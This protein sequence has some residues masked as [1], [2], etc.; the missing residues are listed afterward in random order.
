MTNPESICNLTNYSDELDMLVWARLTWDDLRLKWDPKE[1][2][3][4]SVFRCVYIFLW[5]SNHY[6]LLGAVR[7]L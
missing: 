1:Y 5:R 2:H 7:P 3:G 6:S 4:I